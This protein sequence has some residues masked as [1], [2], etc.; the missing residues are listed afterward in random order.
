[1][2]ADSQIFYNHPKFSEK[3]K[4]IYEIE[5]KPQQKTQQH[6]KNERNNLVICHGGNKNPY[7]RKG[8]TEKKQSYI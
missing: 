3:M 5:R 7:S 4:R 6:G 8:C 2:L 1:M